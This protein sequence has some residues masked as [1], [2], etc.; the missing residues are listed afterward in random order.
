MNEVGKVFGRA[1]AAALALM[2]AA[3]AGAQSY[4]DGFTFLKAVRDRDGNKATELASQPGTT[5]VNVRDPASGDAAIHIVTRGRDSAWLSFLLSKGAR[6]DLQNGR[7]ETALSIA[8]QLSWT[9]GADLLL[10]QGAGV[11]LPNQ[12]GET[13][14]ILAVHNRDVPMV[15]L[16]L[17]GGAN[18]KKADHAAGY[19]AL[20]YA[21]QD[22]RAQPIVRLLEGQGG[23]PAR[24]AAGPKF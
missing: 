8:A 12:R 22:N 7:G 23:A 18:P 19:S 24:P 5:V 11:D 21:R 1:V 6:P 20:D 16:L 17:R 2:I 3:P 13:P 4:S 10:S 15:R 14:L 9:D